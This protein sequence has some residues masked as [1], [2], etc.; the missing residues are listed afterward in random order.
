MQKNPERDLSKTLRGRGINPVLEPSQPVFCSLHV[1]F[2]ALP[3]PDGRFR[4]R[5]TRLWCVHPDPRTH[6][7]LS[8]ICTDDELM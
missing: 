7:A 2:T 4:K 6:G 8:A 5:L 1:P 3:V